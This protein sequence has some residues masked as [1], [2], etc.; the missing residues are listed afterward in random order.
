M[1][2]AIIIPARFASTRL[3]GKPL[4]DLCGKPL[5]QHVVERASG[6]K[7][8]MKVIVATDDDRIAAA[9]RGFGGEVAMTRADHRSGSER[10]AE[11]AATIDA[12]IIVNLQGDE[13][14]IDP[15]HIDYLIGIQADHGA[16]A[17]TLACKFPSNID[18]ADRSAVKA[19]PG[20]P[21]S[22]GIWTAKYFTRGAPSTTDFNVAPYFLHV[23]IYAFSRSSL[24]KF[25]SAPEGA[26]EKSESLE[27]LRILEMGEK[28]VLG[29]VDAAVPGIDTPADLEAARARNC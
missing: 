19:I 3:P 8:A 25:A 29:E 12:D 17:T 27:Q 16:F 23:G 24:Q 7:K 18:V 9:V 6:A 20:D 14:E 15:E 28:I 13:P 22:G 5:I 2:A 4:A 10:A 21:L 11:V 26:L 1:K